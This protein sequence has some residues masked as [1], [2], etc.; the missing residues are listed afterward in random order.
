MTD[1]TTADAERARRTNLIL[2]AAS[3][4]DPN[5]LTDGPFP[6]SFSEAVDTMVEYAGMSRTV[7]GTADV[8]SDLT[9]RLRHADPDRVAE[10]CAAALLRLAEKPVRT[11]VEWTTRIHYT[12]GQPYADGTPTPEKLARM[13]VDGLN[14]AENADYRAANHISR[15]EVVRREV[16]VMANGWTHIGPWTEEETTS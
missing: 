15:S 13:A 6:G 11:D 4:V 3:I 8:L 12:A 7:T 16:R 1:T 14:M 2:A 5:R 10:I 9:K